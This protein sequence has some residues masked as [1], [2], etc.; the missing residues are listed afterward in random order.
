[1]DWLVSEEDCRKLLHGRLKLSLLCIKNFGGDWSIF[2]LLLLCWFFVSL[3]CFCGLFY[4]FCDWDGKCSLDLNKH[5]GKE[6][7]LGRLVHIEGNLVSHQR[8]CFASIG[9]L[10]QHIGNRQGFVKEDE[11][12]RHLHEIW[13][14]ETLVELDQ[15]IEKFS[16]VGPVLNEPHCAAER[17]AQHLVDIVL[18]IGGGD[19]SLEHVQPLGFYGDAQSLP[20][21]AVVHPTVDHMVHHVLEARVHRVGSILQVLVSY[22]L[23]ISIRL[24]LLNM[25]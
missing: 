16:T 5:Q 8:I 11:T 3:H 6:L 23:H 9:Q 1:M 10:L 24:F 14:G 18:V 22:K 17:V 12:L 25:M 15:C 13:S 20:V 2:F 4:L 7:L 21:L 19:G